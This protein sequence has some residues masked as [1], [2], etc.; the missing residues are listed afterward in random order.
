MIP[1]FLLFLS[2]CNALALPSSPLNNGAMGLKNS[3]NTG[4]VGLEDIPDTE[5]VVLEES[6]D[7]G[8]VG[9][10]DGRFSF[11]AEVNSYH[12]FLS[13]PLQFLLPT[14]CTKC[15]DDIENVLDECPSNP[16]CPGALIYAAR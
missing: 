14:S 5:N 6:P 2:I 3:P 12:P 8:A 9:L 7:T 16:E 13:L 4:V 10:D 15:A 11:L 1:I